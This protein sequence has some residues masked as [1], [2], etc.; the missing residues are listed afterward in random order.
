MLLSILP[1]TLALS[2]RA[3]RG[4]TVVVCFNLP[5]QKQVRPLSPPA[6][7]GLG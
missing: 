7:K 1:L 5:G 6:G 2:P 3:G 4:D